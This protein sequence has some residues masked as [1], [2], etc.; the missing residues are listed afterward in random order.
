MKILYSALKSL[1]MY[2]KSTAFNREVKTKTKPI[3]KRKTVRPGVHEIS[4][5]RLEEEMCFKSMKRRVIDG[6]RGGDDSV[7]LTRSE[8][9]KGQDVD[10][11][12]GKSE[13]FAIVMH[14]EDSLIQISS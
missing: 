14:V 6:D 10:E 5:V 7:D 4:P 13:V 2:A 11:A 1:Q 9:V 8:K 12:H 3:S